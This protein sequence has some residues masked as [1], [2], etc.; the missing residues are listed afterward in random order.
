MNEQMEPEI[1]TPDERSQEGSLLRKVIGGLLTI[2]FASAVLLYGLLILLPTLDVLWRSLS[3]NSIPGLYTYVP[4]ILIVLT[5]VSSMISSAQGGHL[6]MG[7]DFHLNIRI[8]GPIVEI[9]KALLLAL[10]STAFLIGSISYIF[11][12]ITPDEMGGI[13]PQRVYLAFLPLAFFLILIRWFKDFRH[14]WTIPAAIFGI[15]LGLY[16]VLPSF[17]NLVYAFG[18]E[19]GDAYFEF[20]FAWY[21]IVPPIMP[22]F[23]VF[24]VIFAFFGVPIFVVLGGIA[25]FFFISTGTGPEA[26]VTAGVE[27][28]KDNSIPAIVLFTLTGYVLSASKAGKRLV[29]V[30]RSFFSWL[31]GGIVMAAVLVSAFFTTF[32]GASGVT[33]LALGGLLY[34]ILKRSAGMSSSMSIGLITSSPSLGLLFPPSIAIILYGSLSQ[35]PINQL[36][37]AGLGPGLLFLL[38]MFGFGLV[39]AIRKKLPRQN[40]RLDR[41]L[42]SIKA[43]WPELLL[44][45]IIVLLYFTGIATLVEISALSVV[46]VLL[47]EVLIRREL[48]IGR[49]LKTLSSS[50]AIVGGVFII[51][52]AAQGLKSYIIDAGLPQALSLWVGETISNPYVFLLLLNLALLVVGCLMDLYSALF[53]VVPL[54]L[55]LGTLF[56]IDP[57]HLAMIFL[58]NLGLGFITPPVGMN[59]FLT[60]Y[61][62]N[63]PL[64]AVYKAVIPF[65]LLQLVV[66]FLITYLPFLSTMFVPG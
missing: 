47:L 60:S 33:I 45:V 20:S 52:F 26:V 58:S 15:L 19:P 66:V 31:P 55:P 7:L 6:K 57:L 48:E 13:L 65:F 8:L 18:I 17:T 1:Q 3:G 64:G 36:F 40:F 62:F 4:Y 34:V 50:I 24:L 56:G 51:L 22:A 43:A 11:V 46:Y 61:R 30:F 21:D 2:E 54:I 9:I 59:L 12:A 5:A 37:F 32:T 39:Y 23:V 49:L 44:P 35:I 41:A 28:F 63:M 16:M 25:V 14:P 38:V 10:V 29:L 42:F 53:V 27:L